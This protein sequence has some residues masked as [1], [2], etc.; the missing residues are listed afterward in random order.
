MGE[1]LWLLD[2]IKEFI[3]NSVI[4]SVILTIFSQRLNSALVEPQFPRFATRE[5]KLFFRW[6]LGNGFRLLVKMP[7]EFFDL[8]KVKDWMGEELTFLISGL[9][10]KGV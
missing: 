2:W 9:G 4:N 6:R 1:W 3:G 10:R 8:T 7:I 5:E